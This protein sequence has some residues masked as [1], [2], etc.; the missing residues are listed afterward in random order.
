MQVG[1]KLN[2]LKEL[3]KKLKKLGAALGKK[4]LRGAMMK[5]TLPTFKT[6]K[7]I[8][9]VGVY[10]QPKKDRTPGTLKASL[11][12]KTMIGRAK[13]KH[14]MA[15]RLRF[16]SKK[17]FYWIFAT[18]G[19]K[20]HYVT[21]GSKRARNQIGFKRQRLSKQ[22]RKMHPGH[23]GLDVLGLA[24]RINKNKMPNLFATDLAKKINKAAS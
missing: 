23:K 2:G 10:K 13:D 12:R 15:V 22:G 19:V 5:A 8:T 6:A 17:A 14:T 24:F 4:T 3:D 18:G 9:P 11:S 21:A 7:A 1:I 16:K 20:P